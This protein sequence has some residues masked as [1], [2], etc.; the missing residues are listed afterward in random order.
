MLF[1]RHQKTVL[2][3]IRTSIHPMALRPPNCS[4]LCFHLPVVTTEKFGSTYFYT[5]LQFNSWDTPVVDCQ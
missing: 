1:L 5:L 2:V 4:N 3:S